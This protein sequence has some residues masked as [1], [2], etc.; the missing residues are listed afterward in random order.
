MVHLSLNIILLRVSRLLGASVGVMSRLSI[1]E[2]FII[3]NCIWHFWCVIPLWSI[4][5]IIPHR[6]IVRLLLALS[7]C[8]ILLLLLR[9]LGLLVAVE[10]CL[11]L[12]TLLRL[13]LLMVGTEARVAPELLSLKLPLFVLHLVALVLDHQS[14]IHQL[15]EASKSMRQQLVLETII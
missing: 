1:I 7:W 12:I 8:L 4:G 2:A 6:Y 14:L 5:G 15:V 10:T 9:M 13:S 3:I 11:T